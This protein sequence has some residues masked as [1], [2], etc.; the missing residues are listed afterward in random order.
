VTTPDL[1]PGSIKIFFVELSEAESERLTEDE[2][3]VVGCVELSLPKD[4]RLPPLLWRSGLLGNFELI[5]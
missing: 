4:F 1:F 5:L 3:D 2:E